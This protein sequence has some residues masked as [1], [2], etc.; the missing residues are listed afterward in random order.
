MKERKSKERKVGAVGSSWGLTRYTIMPHVT[1]LVVE[2][3]KKDIMG[4][5]EKERK[6]KERE[7]IK[8]GLE[9][10]EGGAY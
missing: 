2:R 6:G 8:I 7:E 4:E 1:A 9:L 5:R 3:G 10:E